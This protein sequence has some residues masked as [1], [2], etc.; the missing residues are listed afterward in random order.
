M[1]DKNKPAKQPEICMLHQANGLKEWCTREECVFWRFIEAQDASVVSRVG[2]GLQYHDRIEGLSGE[3]ADWLLSMKK[4]LRS[5]SPKSGR[6]R[7]LFRRR[8]SEE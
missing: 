6:A 7:I 3:S 1:D 5:T 2:C 8:E 4:R